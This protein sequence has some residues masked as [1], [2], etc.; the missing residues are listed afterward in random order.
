MLTRMLQPAIME[1]VITGSTNSKLLSI[2]GGNAQLSF[3]ENSNITQKWVNGDKLIV[4]A[5][6]DVYGMASPES[7]SVRI[8]IAD[9]GA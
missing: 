5:G 9:F 6:V 1:S 8:I 7:R 4:P 2:E 3:A